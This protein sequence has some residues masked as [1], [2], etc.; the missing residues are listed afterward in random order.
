MEYILGSLW[1]L[2]DD[3]NHF[4]DHKHKWVSFKIKSRNSSVGVMTKLLDGWRRNRQRQETFP[5]SVQTGSR[6]P[7]PSYPACT[8]VMLD[9]SSSSNVQVQNAP[10]VLVT[11]LNNH[12]GIFL[13]YNAASFLGR[14]RPCWWAHVMILCHFI[15]GYVGLYAVTRDFL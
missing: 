3:H 1:H 14:L 13:F 4:I 10:Y 12:R 7:L 5:P 8:G 2:N 15:S 6:G 11:F 9:N